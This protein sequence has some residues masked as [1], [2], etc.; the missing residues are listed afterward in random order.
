MCFAFLFILKPSFFQFILVWYFCIALFLGMLFACLYVV[1]IIFHSCFVRSFACLLGYICRLGCLPYR[2]V[3]LWVLSG[4]WPFFA[5]CFSILCVL[6]P[7]YSIWI[8][9]IYF[10]LVWW[11]CSVSE[12]GFTF[13]LI[14]YVRR[15]LVI[16]GSS[17]S[18]PS[19]MPM[20]SGFMGS[21][22]IAV[23]FHIIVAISLLIFI[24]YCFVLN[25]W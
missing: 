6:C 2:I 8:S 1:D 22:L 12:V 4:L 23:T 13:Y 7:F 16:V 20:L 3:I 14:C 17:C 19:V 24:V 18:A 5:L 10:G 25:L 15:S 21:F 11:V 9:F